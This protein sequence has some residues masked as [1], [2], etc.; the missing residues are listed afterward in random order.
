M[1]RSPC[2]FCLNQSI[3]ENENKVLDSATSYLNQDEI[4]KVFSD[5][6]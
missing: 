5:Y 4:E 1:P 6:E 2:H 3:K